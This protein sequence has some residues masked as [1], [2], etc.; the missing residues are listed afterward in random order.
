MNGFIELRNTIH[1]CAHT[2][3]RERKEELMN[4]RIGFFREQNWQEYAKRIGM[5]TQEFTRLIEERSQQACT[6]LGMDLQ[7]YAIMNRTAMTTQAFAQKIQLHDAQ[8]ARSF[9][10]PADNKYPESKE[11]IKA[12]MMDKIKLEG[13]NNLRLASMSAQNQQQIAQIAMIERTKVLDSIY[14]KHGL[15]INYIMS[16]AQHYGLQTDEDLKMLEASIKNQM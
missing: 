1:K 10:V 8:L 7:A 2:E 3:F 12:I 14:V 4:E 9:D 13:E 15:K 16:A 11:E 5:A 6:H